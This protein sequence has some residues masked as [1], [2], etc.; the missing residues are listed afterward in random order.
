MLIVHVD[1]HVVAGE[2]AAFVAA[3][4]DNATASLQEPGVLRF[5]VVSDLADPTHVVLVEVYRDTAAAEAH[6]QTAHY[7][8]WR[9]AVAPLMAVPR[10]STKFAAVVPT[11]EHR[12]DTAAP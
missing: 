9:D 5:D 8:T 3:T 11:E 2:V 1:V 12:W 6:K 10:T 4:I 7:A